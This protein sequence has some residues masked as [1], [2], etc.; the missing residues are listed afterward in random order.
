MLPS[1]FEIRLCVQPIRS[2]ICA[3]VKPARVRIRQSSSTTLVDAANFC[4]SSRISPGVFWASIRAATLLYLRPL[5]SRLF[6][7]GFIM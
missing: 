6:L 4:T 5:G 2:A 3:C 7:R 1:I